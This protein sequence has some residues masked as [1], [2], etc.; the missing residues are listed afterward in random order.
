MVL[1]GGVAKILEKA[2]EL[3]YIRPYEPQDYEVVRRIFA[4]VSSLMLH[5]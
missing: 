3:Y 5:A 2:Q 4:E 1:P